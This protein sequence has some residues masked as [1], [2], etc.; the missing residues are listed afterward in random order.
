MIDNFMSISRNKRRRIWKDLARTS[1]YFVC[2]TRVRNRIDRLRGLMGG[3][4]VA[5]N[6]ISEFLI[7]PTANTTRTHRII[8]CVHEYITYRYVELAVYYLL[9]CVP[10]RPNRTRTL[11]ARVTVSPILL[12]PL[13]TGLPV[14]DF[15]FSIRIEPVS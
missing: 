15:C 4:G 3:G 2:C 8:L 6:A 10:L 11:R 1:H 13:V 12:Q 9:C 14:Q 5:V 7:R